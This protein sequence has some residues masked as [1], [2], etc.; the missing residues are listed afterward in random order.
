MESW[1]PILHYFHTTS[2][3]QSHHLISIPERALCLSPHTFGHATLPRKVSVISKSCHLQSTIL[4]HLPPQWVFPLSPH[5]VW[6]PGWPHTYLYCLCGFYTTLSYSCCCICCGA[7]LVLLV[8]VSSYCIT[9][10]PQTQHL[11]TPVLSSPHFLWVWSPPCS[12][13]A[14][15]QQHAS[16]SPGTYP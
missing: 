4:K 2:S 16:L 10:L 14:V 3:F 15:T 13:G 9:V 6:A 5:P 8:L 12:A 1:S 7:M 11:K